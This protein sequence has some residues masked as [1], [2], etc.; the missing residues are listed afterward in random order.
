MIENYLLGVVCAAL[1]V[2]NSRQQSGRQGRRG[3]FA[4]M[5][6]GHLHGV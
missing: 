6:P 1:L 2:A 3:I 4:G 5:P